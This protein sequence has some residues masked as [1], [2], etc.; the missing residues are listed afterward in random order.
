MW[1][2]TSNPR[3]H[4]EQVRASAQALMSIREEIGAHHPGRPRHQGRPDRRPAWSSMVDGGA[5]VRGRRLAAIPHSAPVKNRFGPT[6]RS[7]VRMTGLGLRR[8]QS[9]ELFLS[10]AIWHA[11]TACSPA[12]KHRPSC[13][14]AGAGG[15]DLARQPPRAWCWDPSRLSMVL[16]LLEAMR[17]Q[18][19]G[20]D[21]YLTSQADCGSRNRGRILPP[22]PHWF[23]RW[24]NA[25][26]DRC[27]YFGEISYPGGA[28]WR[29]PRR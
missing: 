9:S 14:A 24:L 15:A 4:R 10:S 20:H 2:D 5:V 21:V 19:S 1:T 3:G 29:R 8:C 27:G 11:G 7:R 16:A 28:P 26:S 18:V 12:S 25:R 23:H 22:P 6:T 17:G 13:R